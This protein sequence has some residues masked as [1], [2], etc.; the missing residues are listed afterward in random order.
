MAKIELEQEE[1]DGFCDT[2]E[3]VIQKA[4]SE[5]RRLIQDKKILQSRV[6][7]LTAQV[8]HERDQLPSGWHLVEPVQYER[9]TK[10]SLEN[11]ALKE[12]ISTAVDILNDFGVGASVSIHR[13]LAVLT[14]ND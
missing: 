13:A 2:L 7:D 3:R 1:L 5:I 12:R 10:A 8:K 4:T 11:E 14:Q 6:N 9:L